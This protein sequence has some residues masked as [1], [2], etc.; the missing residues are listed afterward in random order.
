M[1]KVSNFLN[2][3]TSGMLFWFIENIDQVIANV[4]D[5][6]QDWFEVDRKPDVRVVD[7]CCIF[8]NGLKEKLVLIVLNWSRVSRVSDDGG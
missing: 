3:Y 5:A 6:L 1:V 8:T 4:V 2:D 7:I